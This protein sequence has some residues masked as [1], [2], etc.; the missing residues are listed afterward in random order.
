[1]FASELKAL[2]HSRAVPRELDHRSLD[3]YLTF[4]FTPSP[5]TLLAGVE[6]L[7]PATC[8]VFDEGTR[9]RFRYWD[10][11]PSERGDLSF[12]E[13]VVQYRELLRAAVERQ[14]MSDRPIGAMLSGGIDSAA[15]V[16][17]MAESAGPVRTFTIGFEG[18]GDVDE[19][20]LARET[21]RLFGTEHQDAFV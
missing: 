8:L 14:M 15:V 21:A 20:G 18:G 9:R 10:P 2:L 1:W 17:M 13:A 3:E 7:E 12:D 11:A 4:R 5:H 19:T 6:K 16:A